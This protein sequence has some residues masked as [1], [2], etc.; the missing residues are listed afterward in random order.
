MHATRWPSIGTIGL[1]L[2][3][4]VVSPASAVEYRLQVVSLF[5]TAFAS[6]MLPGEFADGAS[7]PGLNRLEASL[8]GG[9]VANGSALFDR[10]VQPVRE[11]LGRAYGG[12]RVI[13]QVKLAGDGPTLWDEI[14]WEGNPGERSVWLVS[15]TMRNI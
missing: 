15:P 10:R 8:D 9:Q 2:L 13:P 14:A 6:F 7:G 11:S 1:L 4:A 5:T 12:S 3:L